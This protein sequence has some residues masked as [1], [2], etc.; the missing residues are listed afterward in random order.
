[1]KSVTLQVPG[2]WADH[3]VLKV[4]RLLTGMAG[5][6]EVYASAKNKE[7]TVSYDPGQVDLAAIEG[8]LAQAGYPVGATGRPAETGFVWRKAKDWAAIADRVTTTNMADLT[9]SGDFRKY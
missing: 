1:M 8:A 9:M 2:L 7:V 3:H 6:G 4:R 5:V